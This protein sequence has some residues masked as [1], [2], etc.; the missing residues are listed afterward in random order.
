[1]HRTIVSLL[2]A[3]V[4][5]LLVAGCGGNRTEILNPDINNPPPGTTVVSGTV[6]DAA[7]NLIPGATITV[8]G[9]SLVTRSLMN[10]TFKLVGIPTDLDWVTLRAAARIQSRQWIGL[11]AAQIFASGPTQS[12]N[13]VMAPIDQ[14]GTIRG[15]VRDA[16]GYGIARARVFATANFPNSPAAGESPGQITLTSVADQDGKYTLTNVPAS[17]DTQSGTQQIVYRVTASSA[18]RTGQAGGFENATQTNV[19]IPEGGTREVNFVLMPSTFTDLVEPQGWTEP[20]A[21]L[22]LSFTLPSGITSRSYAAYRGVMATVSPKMSAALA[23]S[24]KSSRVP[25]PGS[26]IEI[27]VLWDGSQWT[28]INNN[29]AGYAI[30][31]HAFSPPT[32]SD[33]DQIDFVRDPDLSVYSDTS[34]ALS[35]G[36]EYFYGVTAIST[37]YL[38]AN[39]QFNP[40]AESR[41]SGTS[42]VRPI[43]QLKLSSPAA[44][45]TVRTSTPVFSWQPLAGAVEYQLLVYDD[46]PIFEVSTSPGSPNRPVHLPNYVKVTTSETSAT[47]TALLPGTYWW[48]VVAGNAQDLE[49]RATAYSI[50]ELRMVRVSY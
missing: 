23:K 34:S 48:T 41:M 42:S 33:T 32:V 19:T 39:D 37:S 9:T 10:G 5:A 50:G 17:I 2:V 12:Q 40:A 25:P 27:N 30:Y 43:G 47:V 35:V 20:G 49:S 15:V 46:Y 21:I 24:S 36:S 13:I 18:G 26:I 29:V 4:G 44:G 14:L 16:S 28:D 31:R 11:R 45:A 8:D 22:A 6:T 1:M 3:T 7:G 38:D